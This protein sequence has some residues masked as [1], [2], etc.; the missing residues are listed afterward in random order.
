M[1]ED[2]GADSGCSALSVS[3][4]RPRAHRRDADRG[5]DAE[6]ALGTDR[7]G[8]REMVSASQALTI[9]IKIYHSR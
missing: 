2:R 9:K 6:M 8:R 4:G 1:H 3:R 7:K 5:L